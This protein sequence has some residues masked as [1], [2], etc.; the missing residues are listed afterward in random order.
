MQ[1]EREFS[2]DIAK[3]YWEE[4]IKILG[5]SYRLEYNGSNILTTMCHLIPD[6]ELPKNLNNSLIGIGKGRSYAQSSLSA[7]YES[8]QHYLETVYNNKKIQLYYYTL[9]EI[10]LNN[11][12]VLIREPEED[13]YDDILPDK[14]IAWIKMQSLIN[15][16][17]NIFFPIAC[18]DPYSVYLSPDEIDYK[19]KYFLSNDNGS[20]IGCSKNESLIHGISEII[21]RDSISLFLIKVFL[22]GQ[23]IKIISKKYLPTNLQDLCAKVE[24]EIHSEIVIVDLESFF[25]IKSYAVFAKN[26]NSDT[27]YKG[28]GASLMPSYAIE[29]AML[30]CVQ[31]YHMCNKYNW[32]DQATSLFADIEDENYLQ[33][34]KLNVFSYI[35]K[36]LFEVM[37]YQIEENEIKFISEKYLHEILSDIKIKGFDVFFNNVYTFVN[38]VSLI[39]CY[40]PEM[41]NFYAICYGYT[42]FIKRRGKEIIESFNLV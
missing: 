20:A 8:L 37:E 33:A 11:I 7:Q 29:R 6:E 40:I 38:G 4:C 32:D 31:Y 3:H 21:E 13:F 42:P 41:E 27:P 18:F 10:K 24:S 22:C 30:E 25:K 15:E 1:F 34:A 28:Y 39:K 26:P 5:L 2:A 14:K 17:S 16:N 9:E 19:E 36:K 12:S 23:K 35:D